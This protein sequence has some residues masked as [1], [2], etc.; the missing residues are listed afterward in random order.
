M[1]QAFEQ[2]GAPS[3]KSFVADS[4]EQA[5]EA[6]CQIDG[7]A[8]IKPTASCGSRGVALIAADASRDKVYR[9]FL[10]SSSFGNEPSAVIEQYIKGPE[11]SVEMIVFKGKINVIT[12]TDKIT[13]GAPHFIEL[14]HTQPSR[15]SEFITEAVTRAA[16]DGVKALGIDNCAA[17]AEVKVQNGMPY[18]MEIG[19]RLGGDFISTK[20]TRLST[21]VD[22]V[23]AAISIAMGDVPDLTPHSAPRGAA[24]RYFTP[25][26]GVIQSIDYDKRIINTPFVQEF[27]IYKTQGH[28]IHPLLSSMDRAG[29]VITVGK[30][31]YE[32]ASNA[33]GIQAHV[34]IKTRPR[35][36]TTCARYFAELYKNIR[37]S[38]A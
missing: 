20:L 14:G 11:F 29:H 26:A 31:A 9:Q 30:D 37:Q 19:A 10:Y 6:F 16:I 22:M 27:D 38:F 7:R 25:E 12:V 1:R 28:S 34:Y 5:W 21:G 3:P 35:I 33:D 36:T 15:Y 2:H 4:A 8:I 32:A 13:T 17:H 24:I 23:A 18:I